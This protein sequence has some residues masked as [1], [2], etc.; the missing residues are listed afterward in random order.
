MGRI[1]N[2]WCGVTSI[3]R[4]PQAPR[5]M[6]LEFDPEEPAGG[7]MGWEMRFFFLLIPKHI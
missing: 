5:Q 7:L 2:H 6:A 4:G 1:D 3:Q